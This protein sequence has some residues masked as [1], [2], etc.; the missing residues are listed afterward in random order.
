MNQN[1]LKKVLAK[2][3][4]GDVK[5]FDS[6]G[7]TNN[8]ALAWAISGAKDLSLVIADEQTAGRGRLD[9]KWFTPKGTALAL[10]IILRPTAEENP[11]LTRIIGL[12]ALAVADSLRTRGLVSQIK[13]P[14]DIL[15]N[16]RKLA[17]I[18]IESTWSGEE[19]DCLVIGI[20]MNVL[21]AAVPS[22]ELLLFPATS[23]EESLGPA[24]Q[25]EKVLHDILGGIIALRPHIGSDSF[26]ASWE[27]ALAFRGEQVQ[28][29]QGDGSL[30]TGKLLGLESDGSLRLVNDEKQAVTVRFGDVRLRPRA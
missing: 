14:N 26:I 7:S 11:H 1:E 13:W 25:R 22:A 21:K 28:V 29:E 10:S 24:I 15:L 23:L 20:G 5:Y 17:G 19:V 16:G 27:K 4:L 18:L 30:I 6:I 3:P 2:L 9:R 12:A 8:E